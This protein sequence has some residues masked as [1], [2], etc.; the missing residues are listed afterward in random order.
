MIDVC[1]LLRL[2]WAGL[3]WRLAVRSC[4]FGELPKYLEVPKLG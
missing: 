2:G 3:G 1:G 4:L